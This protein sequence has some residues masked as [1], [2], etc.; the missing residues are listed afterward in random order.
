MSGWKIWTGTMRESFSLSIE[1]AECN[2]D[3][4][5]SLNGKCKDAKC[6]CFDGWRGTKCDK[7]EFCQAMDWVS[8]NTSE[9]NFRAAMTDCSSQ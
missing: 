4:D 3:S 6:E 5:C 7:N 8:A 2:S 1:D 9:N